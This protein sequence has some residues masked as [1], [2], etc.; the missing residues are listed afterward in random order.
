M[1]TNKKGEKKPKT[2]ELSFFLFC[3]FLFKL[4]TEDSLT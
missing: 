2:K 4:A 1:E 3:I